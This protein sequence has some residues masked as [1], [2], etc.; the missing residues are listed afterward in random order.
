M[1]PLLPPFA[2]VGRAGRGGDPENWDEG[3]RIKDKGRTEGGE[4]LADKWLETKAAKKKTADA[5]AATES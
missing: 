5:A 1:A 3:W 4:R 2:G